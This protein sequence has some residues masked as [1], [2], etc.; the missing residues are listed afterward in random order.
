[1]GKFEDQLFADLLREHGDEL[2]A[3]RRPGPG[4][5]PGARARVLRPVLAA[6]AV[7]GLAGAVVLGVNVVDGGT[8]AYAVSKDPNGMVTVSINDIS[9][10]DGANA[11]LRK[12]GVPAVAVPMR[13]GCVESAPRS[14]HADGVG[15]VSVDS[16]TGDDGGS[17]QFDAGQIPAGDTAVLAARQ[18]PDGGVVLAFS[19]VAGPAPSCLPLIPVHEGGA[20]TVTG[21]GADGG[22]A[23]GGGDQPDPSVHVRGEGSAGPETGPGTVTGTVGGTVGGTSK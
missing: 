8:P 17:V 2:A 22:G 3:V 14:D 19:L 21:S 12:L 15:T 6:A 16:R 13:D 9:G 10:V 18:L 11:K 7:V 5:P 1:M 23:D 4:R 20:G